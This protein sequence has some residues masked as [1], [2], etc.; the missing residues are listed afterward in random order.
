MT[1]D[2]DGDGDRLPDRRD[3]ATAV[4]V[5]SYSYAAS[6]AFT[7]PLCHCK[8]NDRLRRAV[9]HRRRRGS[10]CQPRK[11]T[12]LDEIT[13]YS[14]CSSQGVGRKGAPVLQRSPTEGI[15]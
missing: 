15:S 5:S 14:N 10:R 7:L 9:R 8:R 1:R 3:A 13:R 11:T 12:H 6:P 2:W 4:V